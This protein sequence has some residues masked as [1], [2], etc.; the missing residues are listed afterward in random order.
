MLS[1]AVNGTL[2]RQTRCLHYG[3]H[4]IY[5]FFI[6]WVNCYIITLKSYKISSFCNFFSSS[7]HFLLIPFC[8]IVKK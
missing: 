4:D 5:V 6:I 2:Q 1:C 7:P 8:Y 3:R